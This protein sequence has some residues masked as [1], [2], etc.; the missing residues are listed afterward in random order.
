M[1]VPHPHLVRVSGPIWSSR[2]QHKQVLRPYLLP[3][4]VQ[5]KLMELETTQ[6]LSGL[7]C[8]MTHLIATFSRKTISFQPKKHFRLSVSINY[9]RLSFTVS[10]K[11]DAAS[12]KVTCRKRRCKHKAHDFSTLWPLRR[13]THNIHRYKTLRELP[14]VINTTIRSPAQRE[15]LTCNINKWMERRG[16]QNEEHY[17]M[18]SQPSLSTEWSQ[19]L[20][21]KTTLKIV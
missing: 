19:P 3:V 7:E 12:W 14:M 16:M 10:S 11:S 15:P 13:D 20:V 9:S 6:T 18:S 4:I 1:C 5:A 2:A 8:Q 21:K 17:L